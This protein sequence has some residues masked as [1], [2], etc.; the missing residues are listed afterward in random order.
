MRQPSFLSAF[1]NRKGVHSLTWTGLIA[2]R[3]CESRSPH[4]MHRT[5]VLNARKSSLVIAGNCTWLVG[6][7]AAWKR[8]LCCESNDKN[9]VQT[10]EGHDGRERLCD[11]ISPDEVVGSKVVL[12]EERI[13]GYSDINITRS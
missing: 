10:V 6:L 13:R 11:I 7:V 8:G 3:G 9:R 4:H 12:I 5:M 2:S 1:K